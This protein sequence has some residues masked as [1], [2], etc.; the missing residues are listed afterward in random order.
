MT[1]ALPRVTYSNIGVDFSRVHDHIDAKLSAFEAALGKEWSTEFATGPVFKPLSPIDGKTVLGIFRSSTAADVAG[2]V[3]AAS[4]ACKTWS[5]TSIDERVAFAG[6]W[7][8]ALDDAKYDIALAALYEVGKS[9][10]EAIGEAEEAVDIVEYYGSELKKHAGYVEGMRELIQNE[11]AKSILRPLGVFGVISPFNF[12]VALSVN[13]IAGAILTGNTVVYKPSP[14]C[15]LTGR[16]ILDT[17]AA[18]GAP[19]GLVVLVQGGRDVGEAL[20]AAPALAGV[21]FTGSHAVGMD[22]FRKLA[23]G[24]HAKPVVADMGGKNPAYVSAKADL[25]KA[26]EGVSRSAFGLQGQKC[27]A[28]SA[29]YVDKSVLDGFVEQIKSY[30]SKLKV[31]DPRKRDT[32]MGPVYNDAAAKRLEAA[33]EEARRD[34]KVLV[35]GKRIEGAVGNYFEPTVVQLPAGHRLLQDELFAPF[36]AVVAV[37]S[38]EEGIRQGNSVNYGLAAGVYSKDEAEVAYFLDNAEAGVLYAN[39]ASGATTGAW[40]GS[41]PFCG[42]KG[43]GVSSK[44]GLGPHYLPQF[45]RE[46]SHTLMQSK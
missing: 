9:R 14:D 11:S 30:A 6:R 25:A 28:C 39:R 3:A 4:A 10:I 19:E 29:A 38:L 43:S 2:A 21:A 17:L 40:P 8:K 20:V 33:I 1:A 31:G 23:A 41:Q 7:Q 44:G 18:A 42:W 27:S 26:A 13:M 15:A 5:R 45:M 16:L 34:G 24:R 22:I 32:F 36:V 35:G 46:Q 37:D 12:P